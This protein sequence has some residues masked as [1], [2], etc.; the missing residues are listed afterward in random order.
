MKYLCQKH[1]ISKHDM[2]KILGLKPRND[3]RIRYDVTPELVRDALIAFE[4]NRLAAAESLNCSVTLIEA[5]IKDGKASGIKFPASLDDQHRFKRSSRLL[6]AGEWCEYGHE[7]DVVLTA[8]IAWMEGGMA[9][10]ELHDT[11]RRITVD[12]AK[13]VWVPSPDTIRLATDAF[14]EEWTDED[15]YWRAGKTPPCF[16]ITEIDRQSVVAAAG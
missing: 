7:D 1:K 13:L 5:R 8:T 14:K 15:Y 10:L 11:E 9:E 16:E 3:D 6:A 2:R 12:I 4:G